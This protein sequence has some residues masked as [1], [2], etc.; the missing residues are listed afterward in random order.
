MQRPVFGSCMTGREYWSL[1]LGDLFV[2]GAP[3]RRQTSGISGISTQTVR[4]GRRLYPSAYLSGRKG[5]HQPESGSLKANLALQ[6]V[7]EYAPT[8]DWMS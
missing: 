4:N 1:A 7:E 2:G 5:E 6:V 8:L 3:M